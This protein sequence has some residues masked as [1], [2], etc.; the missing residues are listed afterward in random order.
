MKDVWLVVGVVGAATVV[1]KAVGPVVVGGKELPP[2]VVRVV[3]LLAPALL[4][5]LVVTQIFGGGH[6][7]VLDARVAGLA[8]AGAALVARAPILVVV[9]AAAVATALARGLA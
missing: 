1:L 5:A 3:E 2:S 9:T 4:A 7:L 6:A 8:A